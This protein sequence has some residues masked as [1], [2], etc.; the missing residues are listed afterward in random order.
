VW[1]QKVIRAAMGAQFCLD[2]VEI[3]HQEFAKMVK[4]SGAR[5]IA[6][7]MNGK[8]LRALVKELKDTNDKG[9]G[10]VILALGSEGRGITPEIRALATDVAAIPMT[11]G[12]ESLN[13]AAAGAI[14]LYEF[15]VSMI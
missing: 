13:V 7:D 12:T 2:V 15:Y 8:N 3:G 5:L 6:A 10:G 9:S 4:N 14:L 1:S 11:P